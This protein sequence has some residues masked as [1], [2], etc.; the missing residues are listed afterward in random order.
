[1]ASLELDSR[2]KHLIQG[3]SIGFIRC[4]DACIDVV[5]EVSLDHL[6]GRAGHDLMVL[7]DGDGLCDLGLRVD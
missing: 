3:I 1:M 5:K 2:P 4:R 6:S 7:G